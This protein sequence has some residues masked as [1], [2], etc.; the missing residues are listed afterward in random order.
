MKEHEFLVGGIYGYSKYNV[1]W[2]SQSANSGE[3]MPCRGFETGANSGRVKLH[4][5]IYYKDAR[6]GYEYEKGEF[7]T[8]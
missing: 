7:A 8:V 1:K 5:F 2:L 6:D 4:G 3:S